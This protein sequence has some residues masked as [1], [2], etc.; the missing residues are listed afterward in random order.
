MWPRVFHF[1]GYPMNPMPLLALALAA[2]LQLTACKIIKTAP[3]DSVTTDEA[4]MAALVEQTYVPK[5]MPHIAAAA[6]D[7]VP[8]RAA[9]AGG[10]DAA[11]GTL[12]LRAAGGGGPWN[13]AVKGTGVVV[14]SDRASR[15]A[16]LGL[17][18]D[19]DG[20]ADVQVQLGPVIK[21]TAL[22]DVAPFYV[23]T[24]FRDQI[25]F[26]KLARALNDAAGAAIVLPEGDLTGKTIAFEGAFA[27][28]SAKD[29]ILIV[30][31]ALTVAP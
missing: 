17:D 13:F 31:T 29:A 21:G 25:E 20:A 16:K 18:T 8:L 10:L 26:A 6:T 11:G 2:T 9:I 22:R 27:V 23:F 19:A 4:R 28:L 12:G 7:V 24:D 1:P 30:P 3:V 15:A 14:T 5:L